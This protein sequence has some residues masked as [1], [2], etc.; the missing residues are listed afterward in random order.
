MDSDSTTPAELRAL[1]AQH[2]PHPLYKLAAKAGLHPCR[3]SSVLHGRLPV[4]PMLVSRI[5]KILREERERRSEGTHA[6]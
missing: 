5:N 2:W 1:I 4:S 6:R 3:L